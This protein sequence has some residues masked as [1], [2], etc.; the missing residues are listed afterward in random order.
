MFT[1]TLGT[2]ES[3]LGAF[4]LGGLGGPT[5]RPA[6]DLPVFAVIQANSTQAV[7]LANVTEAAVGSF[8]TDVTAEPHDTLVVITNG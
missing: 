2:H 4:Q 1:G 6:R 3:Q 7:L 5:D 8:S